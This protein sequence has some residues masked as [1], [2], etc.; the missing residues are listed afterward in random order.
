[1]STRKM[2]KRA[3]YKTEQTSPAGCNLNGSRVIFVMQRE[4]A[5]R[6]RTWYSGA[7]TLQIQF[8]TYTGQPDWQLQ[9]LV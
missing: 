4:T 7:V 9:E 3:G 6:K 5:R 2:P 8:A 1:M